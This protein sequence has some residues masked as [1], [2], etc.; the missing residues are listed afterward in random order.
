MM[1]LF[2]VLLHLYPASWRAEY[3]D[4]MAAVFCA[5]RRVESNLVA[6]LA[7]WLETITDLLTGAA[8]VQFDL[9][10]QDFK[11]AIR[12]FARIRCHLDRHRRYWHRR[13]DRRVHDG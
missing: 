6:L 7:L 9:L 4:E 12:T 5:R 10:R 11:Y 8:G 2:R 13:D 3:G 1:T